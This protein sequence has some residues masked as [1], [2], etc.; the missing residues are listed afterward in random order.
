MIAL[1]LIGVLAGIC[2]MLILNTDEGPDYEDE[3]V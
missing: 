2:L 1:F 3:E